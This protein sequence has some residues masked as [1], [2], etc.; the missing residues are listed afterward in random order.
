MK[1]N[2]WR[3]AI[4]AVAAVVVVAVTAGATAGS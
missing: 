4:M 2:Q 1:P 3:S